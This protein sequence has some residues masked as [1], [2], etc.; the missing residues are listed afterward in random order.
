MVLGVRDG[1][2]FN[3]IITNEAKSIESYVEIEVSLGIGSDPLKF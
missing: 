2:K 1:N 3:P